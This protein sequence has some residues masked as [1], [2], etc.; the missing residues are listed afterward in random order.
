M[1]RP[2]MDEP[3][4]AADQ[5]PG[6]SHGSDDDCAHSSRRPPLARVPGYLSV[7]EAAHLIGVSERTIYGYVEAGKLPAL[8]IGNMMVIDAQRA[9]EYRR[10][11]PGRIRTR[12]PAWHVPPENNQLSLT[13]I[14]VRQRPGQSEHLA[15]RL[16]EM[17]IEGQHLLPGTAARYI[18]RSQSDSD[19]IHIVLLWRAALHPSDQQRKKA[20][21]ALA[22][23]FADVL[24]WEHAIVQTGQVLLH[25]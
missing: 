14:T 25:A 7:K 23:D 10:Q 17:R 19:E 11:A 3:A 18:A 6:V 5:K 12:V 9:R 15:E 22:A 20:L 4:D 8:R 1:H 24:D 2:L 16:Q 13:N 21:A